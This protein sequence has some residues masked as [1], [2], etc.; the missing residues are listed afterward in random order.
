[1]EDDSSYSKNNHV[2]L[3]SW[4]FRESPELIDSI[5]HQSRNDLVSTNRLSDES[6]WFYPSKKELGDRQTNRSTRRTCFF[7]FFFLLRILSSFLL[8]PVAWHHRFYCNPVFLFS[9]IEFCFMREKH[10]LWRKK[11]KCSYGTEWQW[12][13]YHLS[14]FL[15]HSLSSSVL[16]FMRLSIIS[17]LLEK[18]KKLFTINRQY[19]SFFAS[20][21]WKEKFIIQINERQLP[22]TFSSSWS[23]LCRIIVSM[24]NYF[25]HI[26]VIDHWLLHRRSDNRVQRELRQHYP[27]CK[28]VPVNSP[29]VFCVDGHFLCFFLPSLFFYFNYRRTIIVRTKKKAQI[30]LLLFYWPLQLFHFYVLVRLY[31]LI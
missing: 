22:S 18:Q 16:F 6:R 17:H 28:S 27:Q 19:S 25:I 15:S 29:Q 26:H 30:L 8:L 9:T 14:S 3:W 12:C 24:D 11:N 31:E 10:R 13:H 21:Y 1:M 20:Q 23:Y 2:C 5:S 7:S 4:P